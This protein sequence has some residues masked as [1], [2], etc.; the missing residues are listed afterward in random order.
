LFAILAALFWGI[1]AISLRKAM[2]GS[3]YFSA[4]LVVTIVG[5]VIFWPI[6][7][8]FT[9]LSSI[10]WQ[11]AIFFIVA[12]AFTPSFTR[13]LNFR[14][15]E[16]LGVSLNFSAFAIWPVFSSILAILL[17]AENLTLQIAGGTALVMV[18]VISV[19]RSMVR[20]NSKSMKVRRFDL[21]YPLSS[22]VLAGFG[23]V[24]RKIGLNIYDEPILGLAIGYLIALC[25]Y[26]V[27]LTYSDNL[28]RSVSFGKHSFR[29]FWVSGIW[30]SIGWLF[31]FYAVELGKVI[32]VS[33]ILSLHPL[34]VVALSLIFLKKLEAITVKLVVGTLVIILGVVLVMI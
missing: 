7:F 16:K 26:A 29:V 25:I 14:G 32:I 2:L 19:E 9:D 31:Y 10:N 5:L 28:R 4:T 17:L 27:I 22:A 1:G 11:G 24:F 3:D 15:I 18:G 33:P 12:G 30:L 13:L 21:I 6:V 8:L 20:S 34:F 23:L